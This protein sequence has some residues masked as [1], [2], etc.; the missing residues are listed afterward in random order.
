MLTHIS[1][2]TRRDADN[3]KNVRFIAS[4]TVLS[5]SA[6]LELSLGVFFFF[7]FFLPVFMLQAWPDS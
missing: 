4:N 6:Q 5:C 3:V 7:F 2:A 1:R